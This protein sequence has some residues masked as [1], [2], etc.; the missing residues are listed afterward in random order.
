MVVWFGKASEPP[1]EV[2]IMD[3]QRIKQLD[4][5]S[6]RIVELERQIKDLENNQNTIILTIEKRIE[7][8]EQLLAL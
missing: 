7:V 2:L 3:K 4:D 8:I 5:N 6:K 1:H